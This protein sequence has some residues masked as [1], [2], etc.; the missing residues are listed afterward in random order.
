MGFLVSV[1]VDVPMNG[2]IVAVSGGVEEEVRRGWE[3]VLSGG[4]SHSLQSQSVPTDP[5][6]CT[7]HTPSPVFT[8]GRSHFSFSL[9]IHPINS[10]LNS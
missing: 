5:N 9:K 10:N 2:Y 8:E 4:L 6:V 7:F 3:S 1:C